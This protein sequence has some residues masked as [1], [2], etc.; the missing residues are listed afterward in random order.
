MKTAKRLPRRRKCFQRLRNNFRR[1][2][3]SMTT[4]PKVYPNSSRAQM[5]LSCRFSHTIR[6]T[7]LNFQ[8]FSL[9]DSSF[10]IFVFPYLLFFHLF[11]IFFPSFFRLF[12]R[13]LYSAA[14]A[15]CLPRRFLFHRYRSHFFPASFCTAFLQCFYSRLHHFP[16]CSVTCSYPLVLPRFFFPSHVKRWTPPD[17]SFVC[18]PPY[19]KSPWRF[20]PS[21][22][23]AQKG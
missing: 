16:L 19:L 23:Q 11:S 18:S 7:F 21:S 10:H 12:F 5:G 17:G 14:F 3:H 6:S 22:S 4:A 13:L 15:Y 20:V 8:S 2:F 1:H 9:F